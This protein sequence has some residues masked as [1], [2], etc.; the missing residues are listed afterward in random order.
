[1]L[2]TAE[3]KSLRKNANLSDAGLG[4]LIKWGIKDIDEWQHGGNTLL[5]TIMLFAPLAVAAG[6]TPT[7]EKYNMDYR[8]SA[9]KHGCSHQSLNRTGLRGS[10]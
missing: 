5:G 2:L 6:M 10:I 1:M 7:D 4:E 8:G 3:P 9:Q